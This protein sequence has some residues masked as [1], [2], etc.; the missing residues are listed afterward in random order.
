MDNDEY[1]LL[2]HQQIQKLR[3]EVERLKYK[4]NTDEKD[5][6]TFYSSIEN[7]SGSINKLLKIFEKVEE[8]LQNE[9][10]DTSHQLEKF[11]K[12]EH[13]SKTESYSKIDKHILKELKEENEELYDEN[14]LLRQRIGELEAEAYRPEKPELPKFEEHQ[15]KQSTEPPILPLYPEPTIEEPINP[16]PINSV[17]DTEFE[18]QVEEMPIDQQMQYQP[19]TVKAPQNIHDAIEM[20][21]QQQRQK[22]AEPSVQNPA[23]QEIQRQQ[24]YQRAQEELRRQEQERIAIQEQYNA[25]RIQQMTNRSSLQTQNKFRNQNQQMNSQNYQ[26]QN[27]RPS[28]PLQTQNVQPNYGVQNPEPRT[29]KFEQELDDIPMPSQPQRMNYDPYEVQRMEQEQKQYAFR[30][31][32][33]PNDVLTQRP[34]NENFVDPGFPSAQ[35]FESEVPRNQRSELPPPVDVK[36]GQKKFMGLF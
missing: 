35:D 25:Q 12:F 19:G 17:Q 22:T 15:I 23:Y 14:D 16:R 29:Q 13:T 5:H 32:R 8:E 18:P 11:N 2:P 27:L 28:E 36:P 7:L 1:E 24:E 33:M 10:I 21:M 30:N 6:D 26:S 9:Q 20:K 3:E 34:P 31:Q 4:H